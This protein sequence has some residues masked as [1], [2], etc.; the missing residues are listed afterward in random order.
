[1][2]SPSSGCL[3]VLHKSA[4]SSQASVLACPGSCRCGVQCVAQTLGVTIPSQH[5]SNWDFRLSLNFSLGTTAS[6][7]GRESRQGAGQAVNH[8]PAA[9]AGCCHSQIFYFPSS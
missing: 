4:F 3:P 6:A 9:Q 5:C 8:L 2:L 7:T 1:M